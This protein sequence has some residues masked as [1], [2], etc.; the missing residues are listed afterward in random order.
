MSFVSRIKPIPV[1][2]SSLEKYLFCFSEICGSSL[3]IPPHRRGAYRDRHERG[4]GCGGRDGVV[5]AWGRRA[6]QFV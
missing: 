2:P 3:A 4:V 1:I 6:E 5:C